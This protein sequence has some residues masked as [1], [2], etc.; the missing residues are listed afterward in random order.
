MVESEESPGNNGY[1]IFLVIDMG[2]GNVRV[3]IVRER[4]VANLTGG[5]G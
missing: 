1:G 5:E 3:D 2:E 4:L